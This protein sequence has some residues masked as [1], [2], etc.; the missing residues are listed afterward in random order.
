MALSSG[1]DWEEICIGINPDLTLT[2]TCPK[3]NYTP[4]TVDSGGG[5][6]WPNINLNPNPSLSPEEVCLGTRVQGTS[7]PAVRVRVRVTYVQ[8]SRTQV[9]G[10]RTWVRSDSGQTTWLARPMTQDAKMVRVR[11]G[12]GVRGRVRVG[13]RLLRNVGVRVRVR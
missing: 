1:T 8:F 3:H 9:S 5:F 10:N 6:S 4:G 2:L 7:S 13:S 12:V 11:V